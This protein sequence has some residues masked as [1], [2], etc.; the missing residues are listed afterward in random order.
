MQHYAS[1]RKV[2]DRTEYILQCC[3]GRRVLHLGAADHPYTKMRLEN[4]TWLHAR[5][6][7]VASECLGVELD[8]SIVQQLK[9]QHG[10]SNIVVGDAENLSADKHGRWDVV[11]A[12]EIIEHL[13]APGHMMRSAANVLTERGALVITTTN[14]YC[15]RRCIRLVTGKESI[16]PDHVSFY[17]HRTLASLA[18]RYGF[19]PIE[20]LNYRME[21]R[22]AHL[23]WFVE[24]VASAVVPAWGEG[25]IHHYIASPLRK[26]CE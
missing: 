12:G 4:G 21:N 2:A 10:I 3:K 11:V 7:Q 17:S 8:P 16:H 25:I 15:L 20:R 22:S 6:T 1:P 24:R 19:T 23:A 13:N 9:T 5:I 14:A 26:Q 18:N